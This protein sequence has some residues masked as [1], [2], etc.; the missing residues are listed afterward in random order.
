MSSAGHRIE[1]DPVR[2]FMH[3]TL[4][5]DWA[6]ADTDG[7]SVDH[8]KATH[9][10]KVAGVEHGNFLTLVD[11]RDKRLDEQTTIVEFR[12]SFEAGSPSR[13]TAI[14]V[15]PDLPTT[16]AEKIAPPGRVLIAYTLEDAYAWLFAA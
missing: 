8:A 11:M 12:K 15:S 2:G 7:L 10:M 16:M 9:A 3:V 6:N 14:V 4:W 13:R 5:G 1:I